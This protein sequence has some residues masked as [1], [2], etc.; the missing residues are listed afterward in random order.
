MHAK[1]F[2]RVFAS[3]KVFCMFVLSLQLM[4]DENSIDFNGDSLEKLSK[5]FLMLVERFTLLVISL[6]PA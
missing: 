3:I 5:I 4:I 6:V 1:I 2:Q